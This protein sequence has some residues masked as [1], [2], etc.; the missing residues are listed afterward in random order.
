MIEGPPDDD[1]EQWDIALYPDT[2]VGLS[3]FMNFGWVTFQ[4]LIDKNGNPYGFSQPMQRYRSKIIIGSNIGAKNA[5]L[6]RANNGKIYGA[7]AYLG[8]EKGSNTEIEIADMSDPTNIKVV[9]TLPGTSPIPIIRTIYLSNSVYLVTAGTVPPY[10]LVIF[11]VSNPFQPVEVNRISTDDM[12]GITDFEVWNNRVYCLGRPKNASTIISVGAFDIESPSNVKK[13]FS[14]G[15]LDW[16]Y[17]NISGFGDY[18]VISGSSATSNDLPII[19]YDLK[20]VNRPVNFTIEPP[21][22]DWLYESEMDT[23]LFEKGSSLI[24]YRAAYK[25]MS[26]TVITKGCFK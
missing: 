8:G 6:F 14:T 18:L 3:M 22:G 21:N 23:L 26:Y 15:G 1:T 2:T 13:V 16:R 20:Q 10:G 12:Y 24:F 17:M 25:R 9:S 11:D 5:V 7:A 4:V 19:V